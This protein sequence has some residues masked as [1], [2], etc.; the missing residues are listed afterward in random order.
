MTPPAPPTPHGEQPGGAG[1]HL[2]NLNERQQ[3]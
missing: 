3:T 1:R 2:E